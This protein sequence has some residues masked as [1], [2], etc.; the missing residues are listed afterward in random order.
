MKKSF[1]PNQLPSLHPLRVGFVPLTDCA[2]L[3]LAHELG[4]FSKY[5]LAVTLSREIG[6]AT[7]RDKIMQGELDAAHALAAMPFAGTLGLGSLKC[8]CVAGLVLN[9][10]GNAITLS[11]DLWLRGVRDAKSLRHEIDRCRGRRVFTLGVV[12]A[13]SSHNLL[14]RQWLA[15]GG[16]DPDGDVRIVV[17][18]APAMFENLKSGNLD[19]YCVGEQWNSVAVHAGLGWC[20]ATSTQLA[21]R[22]PEKVLLVRRIFAEQRSAE[23]LALIAALIEACAFCD[24]P[25]NREQVIATLAQP[26]YLNV[27]ADRLRGGLIGQFN[28]G[29]GR[30]ESLPD[31]QVFSR[32]EANEPTPAKAAWVLRQLPQLGA[33]AAASPSLPGSLARVFR[34]DIF[35]QAR[36]LV[37]A[38]Q[39]NETKPYEELVLVS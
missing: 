2:P 39:P 34:A 17:V 26:K 4:L 3:V 28:Y 8:D 1:T 23:H 37:A 22:H 38:T 24:Q 19:G 25:E 29:H 12:F 21:P 13:Y 15:T 32:H 27:P 5:G 30:L 7:V 18:P 14:L 31:F 9:L 36:Q 10:N 11:R 35:Q 16:V 33:D 6:W 20:A